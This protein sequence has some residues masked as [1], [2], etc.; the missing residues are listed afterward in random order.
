MNQQVWRLIKEFQN[1]LSSND[2]YSFNNIYKIE[3]I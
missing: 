1:K 2:K 3:E